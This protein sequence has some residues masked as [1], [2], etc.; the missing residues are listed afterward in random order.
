LAGYVAHMTSSS[1]FKNKIIKSEGPLE[2]TI[3]KE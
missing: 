1:A 3:P 2:K